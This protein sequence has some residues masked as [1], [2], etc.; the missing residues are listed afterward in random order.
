MGFIYTREYYSGVKR[1][2]IPTHATA[3]MNFE[4]IM[5]VKQASH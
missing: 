5:Q 1:R 3:W 4:D 2:E